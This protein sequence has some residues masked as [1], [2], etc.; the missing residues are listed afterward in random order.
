MLPQP[1]VPPPPPTRT[2]LFQEE[3]RANLRTL[4][5]FVT[6]TSLFLVVCRVVVVGFESTTL[7]RTERRN[8]DEVRQLCDRGVGVRST[9]MRALCLALAAEHAAPVAIAVV[10]RTASAIG[11]DIRSNLVAPLRSSALQWMLA[12]LCAAPW[13][14]PLLRLI[15]FLHIPNGADRAPSHHNHIIV[16]RPD[17]MEAGGGDARY[18]DKLRHRVRPDMQ[19]LG[20]PPYLEDLTDRC[21]EHSA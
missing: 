7:I 9:K 18:D 8:D 6:L 15:G 20:A 5:R 4:L 19:R 11:G 1:V 13:I 10:L 17:A 14:I 12:I 2:Q 16:L 21:H 3:A